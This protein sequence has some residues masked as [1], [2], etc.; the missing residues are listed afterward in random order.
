MARD[1]KRVDFR[2]HGVQLDRT[3]SDVLRDPSFRR[4]RIIEV[5]LTY[6]FAPGP[7][8]DAIWDEVKRD[9]GEDVSPE[10]FLN[11]VLRR[12]RLASG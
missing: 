7:P 10:L 3:G 6:T 11:E 9:I 1:G 4:T 12:V 8:L 5:R 2:D